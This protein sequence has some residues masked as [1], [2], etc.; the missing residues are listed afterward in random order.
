MIKDSDHK[1]T[2]RTKLII[3]VPVSRRDVFIAKIIL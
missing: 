2:S 1:V 3:Y